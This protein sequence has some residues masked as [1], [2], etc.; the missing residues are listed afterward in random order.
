MDNAL[1]AIGA[2]GGILYL[3]IIILL[4]VSGWKIFEK[5]GKPGWAY[6]IPIYNIIVLLEIVG[7]PIWWIIL[8]LIPFVNIIVAIIVLH[9]LS[10]K[11]GKGAGFTVGLLLLGF[12][13]MPILAFGDAKYQG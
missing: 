5:A 6:I 4:I 8:F 1:G 3:A 13:F 2:V 11:F 12:I 10:T 7:K 9:G